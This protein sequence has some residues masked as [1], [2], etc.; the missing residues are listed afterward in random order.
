MTWSSSTRVHI[1]LPGCLGTRQTLSRSRILEVKVKCLAALDH[2]TEAAV[3]PML[4]CSIS[5]K[6]SSGSPVIGVLIDMS[7]SSLLSRAVLACLA[8]VWMTSLFGGG[9]SCGS[10]LSFLSC[11]T[12]CPST[13]LIPLIHVTMTFLQIDR[14]GGTARGWDWTGDGMANA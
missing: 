12:A 5:T 13:P 14:G 9:R 10:R 4:W 3:L 7:P 11:V 1:T 8:Q 2:A 6:V